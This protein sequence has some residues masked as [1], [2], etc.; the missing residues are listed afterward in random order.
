M[1]NLIHIKDDRVKPG[2]VCKPSARH[3]TLA[4][5]LESF[6]VY[7]LGYGGAVTEIIDEPTDGKG[8][9]TTVKVVT[10]IMGCIDTTAFSGSYNDMLVFKKLCYCYDL[11]SS[12]LSDEITNNVFDKFFNGKPEGLVPSKLLMAN[13]GPILVGA[14]ITS[15][16]ALAYL[17]FLTEDELKKF[18]KL[19]STE[20]LCAAIALQHEGVDKEDIIA[21]LH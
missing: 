3:K 7:E 2:M 9:L 8:T 6:L 16:A 15:L 13:M 17:E 4:G 1:S 10:K 12:S 11:V 14:K 19:P 20:D 18:D 21:L 5:A